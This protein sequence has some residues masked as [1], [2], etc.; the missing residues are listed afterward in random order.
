MR[1]EFTD[2]VKRILAARVGNMCSNPDCRALTSGPQIDPSKSLNVG[3]AAHITAASPGGPR[4]DP[5]LSPEDRRSADNGI[6]LCQNC[7]KLI[8]NDASRCTPELL[9][10]WKVV[11]EDA[12]RARVG[13]AGSGLGDES[14]KHASVRVRLNQLAAKHA[15]VWI[16]PVLPRS[17]YKDFYVETLSAENAILTRASSMARVEIPV[18]RIEEVIA[19]TSC[20]R[21][22]I[23]LNGR[24]QLLT[25]TRSGR[26]FLQKADAN[27]EFGISKTSSPQDSRANQVS[28]ELQAQGLQCGWINEPD[29]ARAIGQGWEIVYDDDGAYFRSLDRP[30]PQVLVTRDL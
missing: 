21:P 19:E 13:R 16:E 23:V 20:T 11:A 5:F 10:A 24:L 17:Q 8:D 26:F 18:T 3:V 25:A 6:W 7:G 27:A 29:V 1:D 22:L 30:F 15:T 28:H 4:H 2:D 9:R 14:G 12:A